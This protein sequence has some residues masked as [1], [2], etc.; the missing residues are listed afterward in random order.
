MILNK[1]SD[2]DLLSEIDSI[3]ELY[4]KKIKDWKQNIKL[5]GKN[6]E[7]V[8]I[9]QVAWCAYYDEMRVQ[10]KSIH[11]FLDMKIR[12]I[13]GKLFLKISTSS[14]NDYSDRAKERIID[15]SPEYLA[16]YRKYLEI[17]ELYENIQSIVDQFKNRSYT[18][19]NI[20][21]IRIAALQDETLY[22]A[23]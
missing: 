22:Y 15:D 23:D 13:R 17:K 7:V 2:E 9:Q 5:D 1:I 8:N 4:S 3:I 20:V 6:I 11:D 19:N 12:Q 10:I 14:S 18:L 16:I 21:N